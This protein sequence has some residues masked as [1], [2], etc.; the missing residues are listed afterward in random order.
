ME[1]HIDSP[2]RADVSGPQNVGSIQKEVVEHPRTLQ[3]R[4]FFAAAVISLIM[5]SVPQAQAG[6]IF[7]LAPQGAFTL[8]NVNADGSV[9]IENNSLVLTGGN[10]FSLEPG[11]TDYTAIAV[12]AGVVDFNWS[13]ST[14]DPLAGYDWTGYLLNGNLFTLAD[15]NGDAGTGSFTVAAGERF[16]FRVETAD[17]SGEPG[18]LTVTAAGSTAVPEPGTGPVFSLLGTIAIVAIVRK[19]IRSHGAGA[20]GLMVMSVGSVLFAQSPPLNF[21]YTGMNITGQVVLRGPQVNLLDLAK[22]VQAHAQGQ[23]Q[24]QAIRNIGLNLVMANRVEEP[25]PK[26]LP[27]FLP[28]QPPFQSPGVTAK[29]LIGRNIMAKD[30]ALVPAS[31]SQT[32]TSITVSTPQSR[33]TISAT[34]IIGFNGLTHLDQRN[35]NSGNQY[36]VEPPNPSIAV[37]NGF[38]LEGVNNAVQVYTTS[39]MPL[40]GTVVSTNQLFGLPAAI[41]RTTGV[42]GVFPTDMRVFY[43][44]GINRWFILQRAQC[45]DSAGNNVNH[46]E[47]YIAV[48]ASADPTGTYNNYVIDTTDP[49]RTGCSLGCVADYP[50]IGADQYGF[51]ISSDE[52]PIGADGDP[53]QY[54]IGATILAI[55]KAQL[56]AGTPSPAAYQF[57]LPT[58]SGF[59]F[60]IAPAVTP[61]GGSYSIGLGGVEFFVSSIAT[62]ANALSVWAMV[63]T[64][65]LDTLSPKPLLTR[66]V[67]PTQAYSPPPYASQKPGPLPYGQ[68]QIPGFLAPLDSSDSRMLSLVAAAGRLFVTFD[69]AVTDEKG[70]FLAG[71]AYFVLSPTLRGTLTATVLSQGNLSA[72]NGNHLL[73]PAFGVNPKGNG[74]IGFTLVGP[75]YFPSAAFVPINGLTVGATIQVAAFGALPEDGFTGYQTGVARWG[76]YATAVAASDGSIWIVSE[77]IPN[78]PRSQYANWGTYVMQYTP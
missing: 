34:G 20:V 27:R 63:N 32:V 70:R 59:E 12:L 44:Q 75:D 51:Y 64:S 26:A 37:S 31:L 19:R 1:S 5:L 4:Q 24:G 14:L 56:A 77:Y 23:G 52:Y 18:I 61:P 54:P 15:T 68:T 33:P 28:P 11:T 22:Q 36:S 30:G 62:G 43:D 53:S 35:A 49:L 8:A 78:L 16:G 72:S 60:A 73:K 48:S 71:V 2:Q 45:C 55:S 9:S 25:A 74:A 17:N 39:G 29:A 21:N 10:N 38:I 7:D 6:F 42:S 58:S 13:Y 66:I 65:S 67:V 46:S 3:S 40:L 69:T 57:V 47:I 76:D 41:D 50:Q